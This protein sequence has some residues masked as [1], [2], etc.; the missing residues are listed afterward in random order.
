MFHAFAD[1]TVSPKARN[2]NRSTS[3]YN[4]SGFFGKSK[5]LPVMEKKS[6]KFDPKQAESSKR[7]KLSSERTKAENQYICNPA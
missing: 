4:R 5:L 7:E 2:I 6:D 3:C 1:T